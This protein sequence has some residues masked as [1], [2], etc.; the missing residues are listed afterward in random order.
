VSVVVVNRSQVKQGK[1]G[2]SGGKGIEKKSNRE[3]NKRT[4]TK[5]LEHLNTFEWYTQFKKKSQ[6]PS[7]RSLSFQ[8]QNCKI[9]NNTKQIPKKIEE[10]RRRRREEEENLRRAAHSIHSS[11]KKKNKEQY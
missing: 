3:T 9:Q 7:Y 8:L 11:L 6:K 1:E 10:E 2:R 4:D 5:N